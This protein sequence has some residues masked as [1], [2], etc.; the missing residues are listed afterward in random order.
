M[1]IDISPADTLESY[2]VMSAGSSKMPLR[3][4]YSDLPVLPVAKLKGVPPYVVRITGW[5]PSLAEGWDGAA[6]C[7]RTVQN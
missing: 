2:Y 3:G 5:A 4:D 1:S 7:V 6:R